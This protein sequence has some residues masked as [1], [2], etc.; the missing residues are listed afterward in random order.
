MRK[1]VDAL[2]DLGALPDR[3]P[4]ARMIRDWVAAHKGEDILASLA[5]L[6]DACGPGSPRD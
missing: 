3:R 2:S 6:E 5:R 1:R 4:L